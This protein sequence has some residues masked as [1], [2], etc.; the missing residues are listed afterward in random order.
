MHLRDR[1]E[2]LEV[3]LC[4]A[5]IT[6]EVLRKTLDRTGLTGG[7]DVGYDAEH[8]LEH[9][10]FILAQQSSPKPNA[11]Q[12]LEN[13]LVGFIETPKPSGFSHPTKQ[14]WITD[15][16]VSGYLPPRH[17]SLASQAID[18]RGDT[19]DVRTTSQGWSYCCPHDGTYFGG[20][21]DEVL[22]RPTLRI[23][24]ASEVLHRLGLECG[25]RFVP[26]EKGA[27]ATDS[28]A[29]FGSLETAAKFLRDQKNRAI[30]DKFLLTDRVDPGIF[31][32]GVFTQGR[33][34]LDLVAIEKIVG[35]RKHASGILDELLQRGVLHR[36]L[37]F[38][39]AF[40]RN[41]DWYSIAKVSDVFECS[42]CGKSQAYKKAHWK[43][44]EEPS[45][46]Y[47]LDEIVFQGYKHGMIAPTLTN[48]YLRNRSS[49]FQFA[50]EQEVFEMGAAKPLMEIDVFAIADGRLVLGEAKTSSTVDSGA[51][52][53][54][55]AIE[56]YRGLAQ[57]LH[58]HSVVFA[59]LAEG[60]SP[61]TL[62]D[63]ESAFAG[64]T[65]ELLAL[66]AKEIL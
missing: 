6:D 3:R 52:D 65:I 30:L 17:P 47:K 55:K 27:F 34:Y 38:Q 4:S 41:A 46:Y 9:R 36:G 14:R 43:H 22:V 15:V 10:R 45:W 35:S 56:K 63:L 19:L 39:C 26:S 31:D 8:S 50:S 59:T 1:A 24:E 54:R 60:W 5:S 18:I 44:P 21:L 61:A 28:I 16:E 66:T 48:D 37:I 23:L 49:S 25:L 57:K 20:A 11:G 29:K 13:A 7:I 58:V 51:R 2:S 64:P 12:F 32:D 33:R 62:A 40:C 42:R 53:R